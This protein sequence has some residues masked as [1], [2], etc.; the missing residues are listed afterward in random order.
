MK[1]VETNSFSDAMLETSDTCPDAWCYN[2]HKDLLLEFGRQKDVKIMLL[3]ERQ[4]NH[5]NCPCVNPQVWHFNIKDCYATD[6]LNGLNM[7]F[8][9]EMRLNINS[10][11]APNTPVVTI[12]DLFKPPI[13]AN[14]TMDL[15]N[16][17]LSWLINWNYMCLVILDQDEPLN[18]YDYIKVYSYNNDRINVKIKSFD[19]QIKFL[20]TYD[21]SGPEDAD[22]HKPDAK[23]KKTE[24]KLDANNTQACNEKKPPQNSSAYGDNTTALPSPSK[25]QQ[26]R[27]C[28]P[29]CHK[30]IRELKPEELKAYIDAIKTLHK[31]QKPDQPSKI[32][33]NAATHVKQHKYIHGV[34]A[35]F[36]WH[37]QFIHNY[38]LKL[39]K[40]NSTVTLPY[41]DWTIDLQEP[42]NSSVLSN[43]MFG[44]NRNSAKDNCVT[45][46]PFSHQ[47]VTTPS[48]HCLRRNYADGKSVPPLTLIDVIS[49]IISNTK[50]LKEDKIGYKGV[51]KHA[52]EYGDDKAQESGKGDD[53]SELLSIDAIYKDGPGNSAGKADLGSEAGKDAPAG[54]DA[55]SRE[56]ENTEDVESEPASVSGSR[57]DKDAEPN[58][59]AK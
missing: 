32:D 44:G 54:S 24:P 6:R 35:F 23:K 4:E 5:I 50:A 9:P 20:K 34:P 38:E 19:N 33:K 41:W 52:K 8:R 26:K 11:G 16:R 2:Y 45:D 51:N 36:P 18:N 25:L 3:V 30:E 40:I 21:E 59:G 58:S 13:L 46:G 37:C 56:P 22:N 15:R 29:N 27:K 31:K 47:M 55:S 28:L 48:P 39:Q 17:L 14:E 7:K 10:V 49:G 42:H 12:I 57:K 1:Q 43:A 53:A